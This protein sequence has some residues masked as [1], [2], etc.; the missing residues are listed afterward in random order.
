MGSLV[1]NYMQIKHKIFIRSSVDVNGSCAYETETMIPD[2]V[3]FN[4][5]VDVVRA[6]ISEHEKRLIDVANVVIGG[7]K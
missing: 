2:G 3:Y 4:A 1:A 7:R 6:A 5:S